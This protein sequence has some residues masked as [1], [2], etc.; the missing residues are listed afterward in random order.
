ML[1]LLLLA[2][3]ASFAQE[4]GLEDVSL[5]FDIGD[6]VGG[7]EPMTYEGGLTEKAPGYVAGK[8]VQINHSGGNVSVRCQDA[9]GISAQL[10]YNLEGHDGPALEGMG[11]GIGLRAWG[12]SNG[13]G[14]QSTVPWKPASI[15]SAEVPLI[16]TLPRQA[17]VVVTNR[18]GWIEI[19][20]CDGKVTANTDQGGVFASGVL[21]GFNAN[22]GTGDVTIKA[23]DGTEIKHASS[24]VAST[25]NVK[26]NLPLTISGQLAASGSKVSVY[27]TVDGNVGDASVSG[28]IGSGGPAIRLQAKGD[29]EM[30]TP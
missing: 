7:P 8:P 22:S 16:V 29:V 21:T 15:S 14:I 27:H 1:S 17:D 5:D 11:R 4:G 23:K 18:G 13:G 6:D 12:D 2:A 9:E 20:N 3:P 25:G 19:L 24:A 30:G 10:K 28:T 26:V